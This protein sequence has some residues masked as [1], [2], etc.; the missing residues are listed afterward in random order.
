M[1]SSRQASCATSAS[2]TTPTPACQAR[3]RPGT[4]PASG[5]PSESRPAPALS[6]ESFRCG[7][8][9]AA[10]PRSLARDVCRRSCVRRADT[11][12]V[13]SRAASRRVAR[14]FYRLGRGVEASGQH[15]ALSPA[16]G[17]AL[18]QRRLEGA[19]RPARP[20]PHPAKTSRLGPSARR[21]V[22]TAV[23]D[24]VRDGGRIGPS[25]AP[26]RLADVAQGRGSG[27]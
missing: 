10:R 2:P 20:H 8:A 3:P 9:A 27:T 25:A 14:H 26:S 19:T 7:L 13:L 18:G 11:A 21:L 16:A 15:A 24:L 12:A 5:E 6:C 23:S 4:R 17:A 22:L 1:A